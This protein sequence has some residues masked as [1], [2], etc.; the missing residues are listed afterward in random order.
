[1]EKRRKQVI[2]ACLDTFVSK[3]V[4][5]TTSRD[6]SKAL[7]LQSGGLYYYFKS[8]DDVVV[9]CAEEA[10]IRLERDLILPALT[11]LND[12]DELMNGLRTR[13]DEMAPTMRFLVH[14]ATSE[15]YK[16]KM[17][18][19]LDALSERYHQYAGY[20]AQHIGCAV[21]EVEPYVYMCITAVA[22]YMIFTEDSYIHPQI[23][24][25]K[26]EVKKMMIANEEEK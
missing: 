1:M 19:V 12:L 9:A 13:A 14:V 20:F 16:D 18:P 3:G 8:K 17:R 2:D 6:L 15:K 11:Q 5:D 10:A 24:L 25:V 22:N 7:Q 23:E 21:E 4:F 26:R